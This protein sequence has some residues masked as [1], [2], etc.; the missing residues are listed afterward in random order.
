MADD[1]QQRLDAGVEFL[2]AEMPGWRDSIDLSMLSMGNPC[3][4]ILGQVYRNVARFGEFSSPYMAALA[5]F[6]GDPAYS[7][8][9]ARWATERGFDVTDYE[10]YH[11]L[12]EA[13]LDRLGY[14]S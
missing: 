14:N 5:D 2:D 7:L 1:T 11:E 12:E 10:S 8:E 4:C 6:S 13:W 3:N 9:A